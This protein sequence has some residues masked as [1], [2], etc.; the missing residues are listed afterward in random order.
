MNQAQL[1]NPQYMEAMA[2]HEL[3]HEVYGVDDEAIQVALGLTKDAKN[4]DNITMWLL[5]NCM[6]GP[7][8]K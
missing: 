8:N 6:S 7:G 3:I 5:N 2:M 1:G 4:T